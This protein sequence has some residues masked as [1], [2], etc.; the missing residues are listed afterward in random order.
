[1]FDNEEVDAELDKKLGE[2]AKKR[3][4]EINKNKK[5]D[6]VRE[7][8]IT[9]AIDRRQ[10]AID[11]IHEYQEKTGIPTEDEVDILFFN[12]AGVNINDVKKAKGE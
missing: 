8:K 12:E 4:E 9:A 3:W 7:K 2:A 6:D 5:S 11:V 1:M 10:G